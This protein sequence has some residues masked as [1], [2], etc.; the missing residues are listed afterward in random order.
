[1]EDTII[2]PAVMNTVEAARYLRV[3][4]VTVR[5]KLKH[6]IPYIQH[7]PNGPMFFE[8]RDLD[9][10]LEQHKRRPA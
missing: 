5:K 4:P 10:Y 7:V 6:R 9:V 8:K 1:M 3:H 2:T